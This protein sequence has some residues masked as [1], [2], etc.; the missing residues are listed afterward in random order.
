MKAG[1]KIDS[2]GTDRPETS[3][4]STEAKRLSPAWWWLP[5]KVFWGR[6]GKHRTGIA[7]CSGK[8]GF[9]GVGRSHPGICGEPAE[10]FSEAGY[11]GYG[12]YRG[13]TECGGTALR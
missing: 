12:Q 8:A 1:E 11:P 3:G 9:K 7:D 6:Y 4:R 13:K 2:N 10:P 5:Y